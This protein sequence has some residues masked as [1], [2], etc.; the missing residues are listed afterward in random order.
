MPQWLPWL[1]R[2]AER[3]MLGTV[4]NDQDQDGFHI[5]SNLIVLSH[6]QHIPTTLRSSQSRHL[7]LAG[8]CR[9][10]FQMR[11][12]LEFRAMRAI[13]AALSYHA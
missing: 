7:N 13:N 11:P 3:Y 6:T 8:A 5:N 4:I 2:P 1:I 10:E 9:C 12:L